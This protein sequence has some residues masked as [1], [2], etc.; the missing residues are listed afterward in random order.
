MIIT[1]GRTMQKNNTRVNQPASSDAVENKI[2]NGKMANRKKINKLSDGLRR[3]ESLY[4]NEKITKI[5]AIAML[6]SDGVIGRIP[7]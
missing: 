4:N 3:P 7:I 2:E 5:T 6:D 1:T